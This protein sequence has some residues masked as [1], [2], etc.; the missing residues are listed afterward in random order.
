MVCNRRAPANSPQP[1]APAGPLSPVLCEPG[2]PGLRA[3]RTDLPFQARLSPTQALT[4]AGRFIS[5]SK[6]GQASAPGP[7]R[8]TKRSCTPVP[9]Y[10]VQLP[11]Q[12]RVT[13][14]RHESRREANGQMSFAP[15]AAT[16]GPRRPRGGPAAPP[17]SPSP[18]PWIHGASLTHVVC[19][20]RTEQPGRTEAGRRR[21]VPE[22]RRGRCGEAR[23]RGRRLSRP[24]TCTLRRAR[25]RALQPHGAQPRPGRSATNVPKSD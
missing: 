11:G 15:A 22:R 17:P 21:R 6:H 7:E 18:F 16:R 12:V 8:T 5:N 24:R 2:W 23:T 13:A 20:T 10:P 9:T 19:R 3:L 1:H 4:H 25:P 14:P